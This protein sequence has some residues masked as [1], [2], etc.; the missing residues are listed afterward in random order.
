[1]GGEGRGGLRNLSKKIF[2]EREGEGKDISCRTQE[3]HP[4]KSSEAE[5]FAGGCS[6]WQWGFIRK[7]GRL[8]MDVSR[9]F[10]SLRRGGK[11]GVAVLVQDKQSLVRRDGGA[12]LGRRHEDKRRTKYISPS[13]WRRKEMTSL[14]SERERTRDGLWKRKQN[15]RCGKGRGNPLLPE[16]QE[17][18]ET[19]FYFWKRRKEKPIPFPQK[20]SL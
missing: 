18:S 6:F 14:F 2:V 13:F 12:E 5:V 11:K 8:F 20:K 9:G 15:I 4:I 19:S 17:G 1:M 16:N 3:P 10:K 7:R